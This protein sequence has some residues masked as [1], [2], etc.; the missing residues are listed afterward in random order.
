MKPFLTKIIVYDIYKGVIL[1]FTDFFIEK[2]KRGHQLSGYACFHMLFLLF[3]FSCSKKGDNSPQ[4]ICTNSAALNYQKTGNCTFPKDSIIGQYNVIVT[5]YAVPCSA[6]INGESCGLTVNNAICS[7]FTSDSSYTVLHFTWLGSTFT[8][9]D[10]CVRLTDGYNFS[11][12]ASENVTW[13]LAPV[14]GTGSFA[15]G[16]FTFTGTV[17]SA[18]GNWPLILNGQKQ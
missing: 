11:I 9:D 12:T 1:S 4:V 3:L 18:C 13:A 6:N 2:T 15:N 5:N 14:T 8:N 16:K 7:A 10:F 17:Q